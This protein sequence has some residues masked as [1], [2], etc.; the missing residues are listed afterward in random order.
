MF[1]GTLFL[2]N[3]TVKLQ[4]VIPGLPHFNSTRN[5]DKLKC[6]LSKG[7]YSDSNKLVIVLLLF[8]NFVFF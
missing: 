7:H 3:H 1:I 4:K 5:S 6:D 2:Q 8:I